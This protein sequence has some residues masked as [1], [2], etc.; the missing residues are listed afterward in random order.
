MCTC[1][2]EKHQKT[3]F[4]REMLEVLQRNL[5]EVIAVKLRSFN[6]MSNDAVASFVIVMDRTNF[7]LNETKN[8]LSDVV[9]NGFYQSMTIKKDFDFELEGNVFQLLYFNKEGV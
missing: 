3:L 7:T 6:N 1:I 2:I 8:R 9:V 5:T 4:E